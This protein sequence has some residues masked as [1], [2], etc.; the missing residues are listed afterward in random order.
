MIATGQSDSVKEF[1][2]LAFEAVGLDWQEY[3][4]LDERF[5]R[6]AEVDRLCGTP[7]KRSG[8]WAGSRR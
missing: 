5:L 6:P 7:P 8:S 2:A 1:L 4:V 3:V